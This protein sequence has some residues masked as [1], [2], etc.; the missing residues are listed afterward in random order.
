MQNDV[1]IPANARVTP[2]FQDINYCY[3]YLVQ[4][5]AVCTR[6]GICARV[7]ARKLRAVSPRDLNSAAISG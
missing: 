2:L 3:Y 5:R 7:S 1:I 4:Y 6:V